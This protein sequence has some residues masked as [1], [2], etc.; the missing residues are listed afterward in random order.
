[1]VWWKSKKRND[2]L[3]EKSILLLD[4]DGVIAP[5][6]TYPRDGDAIIRSQWAT[7]VIP[8]SIVA[9]LRRI[10]TVAEIVWCSNWQGFSNDASRELLGE[11]FTFIKFPVRDGE[12]T[13]SDWVKHR[14]I[15]K[16]VKKNSGRNM[17]I[18]DD[19]MTQT[20]KNRF[21]RMGCHCVI[22]VGNTGLSAEE[23]ALIEKL[24]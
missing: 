3:A 7:W 22:P 24:L 10:S 13:G 14:S 2:G 6:M 18:V 1:M 9:F 23:M 20:S 4:I 12:N 15:E 19:E 16:F 21:E 8:A 5:M 17:V 11:D